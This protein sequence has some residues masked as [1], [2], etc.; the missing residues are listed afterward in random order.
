VINLRT[1]ARTFLRRPAVT[2]VMVTTLALG[3]GFN[4]AALSAVNSLLLHPYP[5]PDLEQLVIVRDARTRE[6][7][8]QRNPV[9]L[10]DFADLRRQ[11]Q[12]F[13]GVA[14]WRPTSFVVSGA[15]EPESLLGIEA[16]ADFFDV[17]GARASL[18]RTFVRGEDEAGRDGVVVFSRRFWQ[19]YFGA[20]PH[21]VGREVALN[22][23]SVAI[24]GIIPDSLCYPSGADA[25]VPMVL[26]PA[27]RVDRVTQRVSGIARIKP[28]I[29]LE[30]AQADA[31]RIAKDLAEKYPATN[32][33]RDFGLLPLRREQYEFTA[34][35]FVF[36]QGAAL[37][38]LCLSATN[39]FT[40][41][42][43]R[44][45]ERRHEFAVRGALGASRL[46][47]FGLTIAEALW[48]TALAA[49][50]AVLPAVWMIDFVR[51]SLPDGIARWFAGWQAI[52]LDLPTMAAAVGL[53]IAV[54]I[55]LGCVIGMRATRA[56]N[57]TILQHGTRGSASLT[58]SWRRAVVA[59]EAC[60][61]MILLVVAT[62][63]WQGLHS[64]NAAFEALRPGRL[65]AV[66]LSLPERRYPADVRVVEFQDRLIAA[67]LQ[68]PGV[69][70]AALIR[71][72]PASNVPSPMTTFLVNRQRAVTPSEA[73][74][75]DVQVVTP[76]IF[77]TL[78]VALLSGR[79]L[80]VSDSATA[81]RVAVVCHTMARRFWPAGDPIGST[82]RLGLDVAAPTVRIVGTVDDMRLNW[83]DPEPRAVIYLPHAQLASRQ[84]QVVIR[85]TVDPVRLA[86]QSREVVRRLDPHLAIG[87]IQPYTS[88]IQESL[89]P[90]RIVSVLLAACGV[91]AMLLA[92][93]G[94]YASLAHWVA[95]RQ[96]ELGVRLALGADPAAVTQLVITEA[97]RT[98]GMGV[99]AAIPLAVIGTRAS[100]ITALGIPD[101][102]LDSLIVLSIITL[103]MAVA[104]SAAPARRAGQAD[105][106]VLLHAE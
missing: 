52:H 6:G 76:A 91:V 48:L 13:R 68:V 80:S 93:G 3:L 85:T 67:L 77:R 33:A 81:P 98:A 8:H 7:V 19:S 88:V 32:K 53:S 39:V 17:L 51:A 55:V 18:G 99:A 71:N 90:V 50:L 40:L 41:L 94:V 23:R 5:Y 31:S 102:G 105:P 84:M 103:A 63:A 47:L 25:W 83:Y 34:P 38:V 21:I 74:R 42:A 101:V 96:P 54:G 64:M 57:L 73:P 43:A 20:D 65:L 26:T 104:A 1:F 69:E 29:S 24:V 30:V 60:L 92:A 2:I 10:G 36:V 78:N 49:G 37:F 22:G 95:A 56:G 100:G 72:E 27:D 45:I 61:A 46:Q 89:S 14:G 70:S 58:S 44:T 79:A 28:G 87:T 35:L 11:V 12:A 62:V 106:M 9:A 86:S 15:A 59:V 4:I 97:M 82:L 16:T 66:G 75:A